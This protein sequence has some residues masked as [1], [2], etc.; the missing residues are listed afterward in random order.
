MTTRYV[1]ASPHWKHLVAA[2]HMDHAPR[3]PD[4]PR[5]HTEHGHG[6]DSFAEAITTMGQP[7]AEDRTPDFRAVALRSSHGHRDVSTRDG[8]ASDDDDESNRAR[9]D[10]DD[11]P[12]AAWHFWVTSLPFGTGKPR[13]MTKRLRTARCACRAILSDVDN[14]PANNVHTD[15]SPPIGHRE[16]RVLGL[17]PGFALA[18]S[19]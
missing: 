19:I 9:L 12:A 18:P 14:L 11:N 2:L 10:C 16:A 4:T 6:A 8:A 17:M 5:E 13:Q 15:T 1:P 7:S 3:E